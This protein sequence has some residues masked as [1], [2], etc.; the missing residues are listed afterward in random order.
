MVVYKRP[1][2]RKSGAL[3]IQR[4]KDWEER[5]AATH[6]NVLLLNFSPLLGKYPSI[7]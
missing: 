5:E 2:R 7:S 6:K 1:P 3:D 4:R